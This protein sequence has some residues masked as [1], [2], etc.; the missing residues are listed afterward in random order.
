MNAPILVSFIARCQRARRPKKNGDRPTWTVAA[1]L[2]A[3]HSGRGLLLQFLNICRRLVDVVLPR[4]ATEGEEVF[5]VDSLVARR[6]APRLPVFAGD[7]PELDPQLQVA[8]QG[9]NRDGQLD[10]HVQL[11]MRV[12]VEAH[13]GT[14]AEREIA[15]EQNNVYRDTAFGNQ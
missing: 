1:V 15:F 12:S 13:V 2:R 11:Y 10:A 14:E 6:T 8:A 9:I 7:A 5:T 4:V 3:N